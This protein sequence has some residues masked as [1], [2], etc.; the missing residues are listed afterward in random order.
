LRDGT[1]SARGIEERGET[2]RCAGA[3]AWTRLQSDPGSR[4]HAQDSFR[5]DEHAV[6]TRPGTRSG[7]SARLQHANWCHDAQAFDEIVDVGMK[8]GEMAARSRRNP[9]AKRRKF[10]T[11]REVPQ[12]EAMRLELVFQ[13]RT[14][15]AGFNR[16]GA[17]YRI[18]FDDF[19]EI[20][21]IEGDGSLML[22]AVNARLDAA[23]HARAAT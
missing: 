8:T 11:L 13:R 16:C 9:A 12:R 5:A 15:G 10:K 19:G 21:Q 7:K 14:I 1:H 3:E 18:H 2:N 6:G 17:R 22:D 20:A 23:A 4:N